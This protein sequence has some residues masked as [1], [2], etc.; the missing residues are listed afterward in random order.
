MKD[1]FTES[2]SFL[3]WE[4]EWENWEIKCVSQW[5]SSIVLKAACGLQAHFVQ[6]SAVFK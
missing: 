3:K 5:F 4:I 1:L 6:P 2:L